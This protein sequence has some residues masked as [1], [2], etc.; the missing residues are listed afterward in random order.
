MLFAGIEKEAIL[1]Q[2]TFDRRTGAY[3]TATVIDMRLVTFSFEDDV[4]RMVCY[5]NRDYWRSVTGLRGSVD[6][7][8]E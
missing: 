3:G 7:R 5:R 2:I 4:C 1:R 6:L 8:E